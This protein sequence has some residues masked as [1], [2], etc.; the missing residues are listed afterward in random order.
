MLL[1]VNFCLFSPSLPAVGF[2][3]VSF[4]GVFKFF[5]SFLLHLL[6]NSPFFQVFSNFASLC[7]LPRLVYFLFLEEGGGYINNR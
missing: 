7:F 3:F 4:F 6:P 1:C 2:L 5:L